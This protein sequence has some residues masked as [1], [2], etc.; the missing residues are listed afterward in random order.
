MSKPE[1]DGGMGAGRGLNWSRD[2]VAP[3]QE[4]SVLSMLYEGR[5][6]QQRLD[7]ADVHGNGFIAFYREERE[8]YRKD[9][10]E[11][12]ASLAETYELTSEIAL[13]G[14][15]AA[16]AARH[17]TRTRALLHCAG[18]DRKG[19]IADTAAAINGA[20]G[21][22]EGAQMSVV[23]GYLITTFLVS[24]LE[25]AP[26]G[27]PPDLIGEFTMLEL[28]DR[29]WPRPNSNCWHARGEGPPGSTESRLLKAL[30]KT[31]AD[32]D[33]PLVLL[34]SW[35]TKG[36]KGAKNEIVDLNFATAPTPGQS[37]PEIVRDIESSVLKSVPKCQL[38]IYA[39]AWPEP[40][41]SH[42]IGNQRT[43]RKR[44]V[45]VTICAHARPGFVHSV[46]KILTEKVD[47][48]E[49][50]RGS[51]M[52]I[53]EGATV[54]TVVVK[55]SRRSSL[56]HL[57]GLIK[58]RIDDIEGTTPQVDVI[59]IG[60]KMPP[61]KGKKPP[62]KDSLT[63][64]ELRLQVFEQPGVVRKVAKLLKKQEVNIT[65]FA[66]R[67]QEPQLGRRWQIC[68]IQMHLAVTKDPEKLSRAL[69]ALTESEGWDEASL[70]DWTLGH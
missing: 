5:E 33:L 52:A 56:Q 64:H 21:N 10:A 15:Q 12:T 7:E 4:V 38:D 69:R 30:T 60:S 34:H 39:S 16:A 40:S 1:E 20:G 67:V 59:P 62:K 51:S 6:I 35:S 23:A 63:T 53:L 9:P 19:A 41:R 42:E 25:K 36:T 24:G 47:G 49:K 14:A 2:A 55:R 17:T 68:D 8:R 43:G 46:L 57:R 3:R 37:E 50:V 29:D 26:K 45:M 48:I 44:D 27:L 66:C 54:L 70:D 31:I 22:I 58:S 32:R 28:E 18:P 11:R 65:W 13:F 61:R